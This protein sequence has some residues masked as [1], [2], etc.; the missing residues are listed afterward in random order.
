VKWSEGLRNR[1][2]IIIRIYTD[3]MKLYCF[4][5]ILLVLFCII[6]YMVICSVCFYLI[7]YTI[8]FYCYVCILLLLCMFRSRY[9]VSLCCSVYCLCVNV[10]CTNASGCQPN[11]SLQ[12]YIEIGLSEF[13]NHVT[14]YVTTNCANVHVFIKFQILFY[15]IEPL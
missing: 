6:V 5:H 3:H 2:S 4:F 13:S 9:C 1:M 8:Y 11:C 15:K 10:Y 14:N 7:L 12:I